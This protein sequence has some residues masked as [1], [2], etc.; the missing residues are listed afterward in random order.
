MDKI[1]LDSNE[2]FPD[3]PELSI[4]L[5]DF[6]KYQKFGEEDFISM[7][8]MLTALSIQFPNVCRVSLLSYDLNLRNSV[9]ESYGLDKSV[10]NNNPYAKN[11]RNHMLELYRPKGNNSRSKKLNYEVRLNELEKYLDMRFNEKKLFDE[12]YEFLNINDTDTTLRRFIDLTFRI[13]FS[14]GI[15]LDEETLKTFAKDCIDSFIDLQPYLLLHIPMLNKLD[16][17]LEIILPKEIDPK[18]LS[19]ATIIQTIRLLILNLGHG[20]FHSIKAEA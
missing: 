6:F 2:N 17:L 8:E 10:I 11:L 14:E 19:Y 15:N 9:L 16:N 1:T 13:H 20:S 7:E 12:V 3:Q 18:Q 5:K 4:Y